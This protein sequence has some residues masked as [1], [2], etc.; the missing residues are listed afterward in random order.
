MQGGVSSSTWVDVAVDGLGRVFTAE[1][2][3]IY[4]YGSFESAVS[5]PHNF[6]ITHPT[7]TKAI[8]LFA[9]ESRCFAATDSHLFEIDEDCLRLIEATEGSDFEVIPGR[10]NRLGIVTDAGDAYVLDARE[11]EPTPLELDDNVRLLGLGS[12]FEVVVTD[13]RVLSR[14]SSKSFKPEAGLT[15]DQFGQLGR[16]GPQAEWGEIALQA[17]KITTILC[18][19][20]ATIVVM[21]A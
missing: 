11:K 14:G 8:R 3:A 5:G 18:S 19:R 9:L 15:T 21:D 16:Y 13:T 17:D 20:W 10:R 1:S 7:L 6:K 4:R 12:D 2:G